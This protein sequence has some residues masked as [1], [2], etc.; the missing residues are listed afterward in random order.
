MEKLTEF[1]A[2]KERSKVDQERLKLNITKE[3]AD[4]QKQQLALEKEKEITEQRRLEH[5]TEILK[6]DAKAEKE[7]L[8]CEQEQVGVDKVNALADLAQ[9]L[10][11][12]DHQGLEAYLGTA[13]QALSDETQTG[14]HL[15]DVSRNL[16]V[17]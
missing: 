14:S 7:S 2:K 4:I 8:K 17:D 13:S 1:D 3:L 10:S 9:Y 12:L 11:L 15:T 6:C 5:A 16:I